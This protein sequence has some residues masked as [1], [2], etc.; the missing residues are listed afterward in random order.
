MKIDPLKLKAEREKRGWSQEHLGEVANLSVRTVQR[1][2][3][4]GSVS[5]ESKQA[6]ASAL[7]VP[8]DFL[9]PLPPGEAAPQTHW[10]LLDRSLLSRALVAGAILFGYWGVVGSWLNDRLGDQAM[11]RLS[12]LLAAVWL[13]ADEWIRHGSLP[14]VWRHW[15]L[16]WQRLRNRRS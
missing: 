16:Q 2:E 10:L 8:T 3:R 13:L 7:C 1:I 9:D 6:L 4:S 12:L 11:Q 5:P 14:E 15:T